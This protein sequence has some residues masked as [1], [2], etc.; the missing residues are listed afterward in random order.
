MK[1]NYSPVNRRIRKALI[2]TLVLSFKDSRQKA[3]DF[4]N[5]ITKAYGPSLG[6]KKN[7]KNQRKRSSLFGRITYVSGFKDPKDNFKMLEIYIG[8]STKRTHVKTRYFS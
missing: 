7:Y 1:Y 3:K 5:E 8:S 4:V 2:N 6:A